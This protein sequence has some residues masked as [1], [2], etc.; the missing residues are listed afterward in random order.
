M[1]YGGRGKH[2]FT[3]KRSKKVVF[4]A[5]CLLNQNSI[6]DGTAVYPAAFKEVIRLFLDR[7]IGIVQLPCPELCCLGLDRGNK[8]GADSPVVEENTRIRRE[9]LKTDMHKKL[10][11][12]VEQV[13]RQITE[14]HSHGFEIVGI[15]GANRSPNC[16][17]ETTSDFN[18]EISGRGVFMEELGARLEKENIRIAMIGIKDT[19][20]IEEKI[21]QLLGG[22]V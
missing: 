6:S 3:D 20:Q 10:L 1:P 13:I 14:Y 19:D 9:M 4:I 17:I 18:Q 16:G 15:V 8:S 22:A 11:D 12:L 2:M 7:D 21:G 5:H